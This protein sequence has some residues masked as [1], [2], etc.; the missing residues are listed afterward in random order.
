MGE[1]GNTWSEPGP[2]AVRHVICIQGG[3]RTSLNV[4]GK[5]WDEDTSFTLNALDV[6]GVAYEVFDNREPS[7]RLKSQDQGR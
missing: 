5:G 4:N 3:G 7:E 2:D 1:V 6:H